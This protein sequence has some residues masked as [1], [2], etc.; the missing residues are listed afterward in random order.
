[1]GRIEIISLPSN[2]WRHPVPNLFLLMNGYN[3]QTL[4]SLGAGG[5][6]TATGEDLWRAYQEHGICDLKYLFG[7]MERAGCRIRSVHCLDQ[8]LC[9][10]IFQSVH[11][12]ASSPMHLNPSL[13]KRLLPCA[14]HE[15]HVNTDVYISSNQISPSLQE[16]DKSF[17]QSEL[18]GVVQARG[19]W[20]FH[21]NSSLFHL[22]L[23][24]FIHNYIHSTYTH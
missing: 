5:E 3:S 11:T 9:M 16:I 7:L 13:S 8:Q 19:S 21:G 24:T 6:R 18:M 17:H 1:M 23:I 10:T 22:F 12:N 14:S 4:I 15:T 20:Y 2:F